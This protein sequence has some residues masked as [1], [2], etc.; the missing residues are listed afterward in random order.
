MNKNNLN[1]VAQK[2][3]IGCGKT[4][5]LTEP[6]A[7]AAASAESSVGHNPILPFIAL[8]KQLTSNSKDGRVVVTKHTTVGQGSLKFLLLNPAAKFSDVIKE[9][10]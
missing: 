10:R 7:D 9:A 3:I 6:A 4:L 2:V 8:V 1:L 5:L